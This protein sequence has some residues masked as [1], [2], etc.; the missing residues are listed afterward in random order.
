MA[1]TDI[2]SEDRLVQATVAGQA[3]LGRINRAMTY[4]FGQQ[5][6]LEHT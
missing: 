1:Y 3:E 2:N 6:W 5:I 4:S